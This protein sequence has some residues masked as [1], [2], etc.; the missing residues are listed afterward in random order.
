[1]IAGRINSGLAGIPHLKKM[2][3]S[4]ID[5]PELRTGEFKR[6]GSILL[7]RGF[8]IGPKRGEVRSLSTNIVFKALRYP[9][10]SIF[11]DYYSHGFLVHVRPVNQPYNVC[12]LLQEWKSQRRALIN[13][14]MRIILNIS[15]AF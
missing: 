9:R 12:F 10:L 5:T 6:M 4:L 13:M 15:D 1:M 8:E 7:H 14:H 11:K 3:W 2:I